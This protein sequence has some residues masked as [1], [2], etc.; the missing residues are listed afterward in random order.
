MGSQRG[1]PAGRQPLPATVQPPVNSQV[2][3]VHGQTLRGPRPMMLPGCMHP[4]PGSILY[5]GRKQPKP[6][7]LHQPRSLLMSATALT[8]VSHPGTG[9][10]GSPCTQH[11]GR[12]ALTGT[13]NTSCFGSA[14]APSTWASPD[15]QEPSL[16]GTGRASA[17]ASVPHLIALILTCLQGTRGLAPLQQPLPPPLRGPLRLTP[18]PF[19]PAQLCTLQC[20][21]CGGSGNASLAKHR[22]FALRFS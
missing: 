17:G 10:P 19:G 4:N 6:W 15:L 9:S 20:N 13:P 8:S 3:D 2:P 7:P 11:F 1:R 5:S 18:M 14:T 16:Q 12:A 21:G 22:P